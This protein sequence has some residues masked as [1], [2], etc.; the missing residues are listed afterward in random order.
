MKPDL[1]LVDLIQLES[2]ILLPSSKQILRQ[3]KKMLHL[4]I[5]AKNVGILAYASISEKSTLKSKESVSFNLTMNTTSLLLSFFIHAKVKKSKD[6]T[7]HA[8]QY[9]YRLMDLLF[10]ES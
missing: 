2:S 5:I 9:I 4:R 1:K 7:Q 6:S 10:I 8:K 3:K